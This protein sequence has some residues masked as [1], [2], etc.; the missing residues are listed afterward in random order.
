M[1]DGPIVVIGDALLDVDVHG[2]CDRLCPDA[3]APV[4]D[5]ARQNDRPGGAGLAALAAAE[6]ASGRAVVLLT[7]LGGDATADRIRTLL[8]GSV[9]TYA[10]PLDG[11]TPR[12][13]RVH[14][15]DRPMIRLDSGDGR[16]R[17]DV[18]VADG[19]NADAVSVREILGA[20]GA[21]LVSDYGRG[22]AAHPKVRAALAALP[23]NVP[24]VWDPHPKG[25]DPL[26]GVRLLTPNHAEAAHLAPDPHATEAR[27]GALA[28]RLRETAARAEALA[29]RWRA[30]GVSVTLG[31]DGALLSVGDGAPYLVPPRTSVG[32]DPCGA[33]DRFAAAATVALAG[34]A[35][36]PEAVAAG[37]ASATSFLAA[38]GVAA[39]AEPT[40]AA[41]GEPA[42][43]DPGHAKTLPRGGAPLFS[44]LP[45]A[46]VDRPG[47]NE[48]LWITADTE[49]ADGERPYG[50]AFQIADQVRREGGTVVATGGCFDILHAGH[51]ELLRRARAL[52][53]CLIVCLNSDESVRRLKGDDRPLV[54]E[55]DRA[56][57]VQAV[58]G[59]DAVV[60]F[61]EDTPVPLLERLRPDVWVK[62]G[63][64]AG[65]RLP[66]AP[67]VRRLGGQ[68]VVLPYL[69]GRST[70]SIVAAAR[71]RG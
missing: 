65:A 57:V 69:D 24:I 19:P 40:P 42:R 6:E 35:L 68:L 64:Y 62:G 50:D 21:V 10:L 38:G 9:R 52:G 13:V 70:S 20:A 8:A 16:A 63:D 12:K 61:G 22:M 56:R 51:V 1:R 28:G 2:A 47:A 31:A 58:E 49:S 53:D 3:P 14:A 66:E 46:G 5:C 34:G 23:A 71:G 29:H 4:I 11:G 55:R 7:A 41:P 26:P 25:A 33:G 44:I 15:G 39:L 27:A 48:R 17:H 18:A 30:A 59:V 60:V 45:E 54:S 36:L 43:P 37:V 67:V 32:G